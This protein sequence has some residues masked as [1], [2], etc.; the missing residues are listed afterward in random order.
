[1]CVAHLV[2]LLLEKHVVVQ[3]LLPH[4]PV[5]QLLLRISYRGRERDE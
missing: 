3:Q 2:R 5:Q 4:G 1:M